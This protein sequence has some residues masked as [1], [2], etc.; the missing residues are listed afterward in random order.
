[1]AQGSNRDFDK[2]RDNSKKENFF[3]KSIV[4]D[5]YFGTNEP[6]VIAFHRVYF[7]PYA[8]EFNVAA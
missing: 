4:G 6:V 5:F 7:S 2:Y 1:M 3:L 8:T